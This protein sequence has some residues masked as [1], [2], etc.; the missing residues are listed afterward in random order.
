MMKDAVHRN[1]DGDDGKA[2]GDDVS[3]PTAEGWGMRPMRP[4]A[5]KCGGGG[6]RMTERDAAQWGYP[7]SR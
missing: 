6:L 3:S 1:D 5:R 2:D 4:R 7:R